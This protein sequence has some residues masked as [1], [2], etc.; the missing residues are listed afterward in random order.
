MNSSKKGFT[1]IELLVVIAIIAILAAMLLPALSKARAKAKSSAC[2]NNMKQLGIV[3]NMYAQDWDGWFYASGWR[4]SAYVPNYYNIGDIMVCPAWPPYKYDA[5]YPNATYGVRSIAPYHL[6]TSGDSA[7]HVKIDKLKKPAK[8][9]ILADTVLSPDVSVSYNPNKPYIRM[10][11]GGSW[12]YEGNREYE[13]MAHFRHN[14]MVNILFWDG[15]AETL[16]PN[17]LQEALS[18][19]GTTGALPTKNGPG[20]YSYSWWVILHD[21]TRVQLTTP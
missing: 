21:W 12:T 4:G 9:P 1:L 17:G 16:S 10:Q 14:K 7:S 15:H 18:A 5:D 20:N 6:R 19:E 13:G 11:Y 8:Y 3:F 2:L